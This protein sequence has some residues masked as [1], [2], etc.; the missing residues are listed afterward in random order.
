MPQYTKEFSQFIA[1]MD[2][3]CLNST[4]IAAVCSCLKDFVAVTIAGSSGR[5]AEI[6]QQYYSVMD[7]TLPSANILSA[8]FQRAGVLEAAAVNAVSG[9]SLD[10]DDVHTKSITHLAAVTIPTALAQT[11]FLWRRDYLGNC[12]GIR[13]GGTNR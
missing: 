3:S 1:K 8:R 5:E 2:F 10:L 6:W 4:D 11:E 12:S 9:H 13:G 7:N